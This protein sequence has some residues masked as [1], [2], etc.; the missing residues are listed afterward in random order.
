MAYLI[1]MLL[2]VTLPV[3][4]QLLSIA[5][6]P[7]LLREET[8]LLD[9]EGKALDVMIQAKSPQKEGRRTTPMRLS[10]GIEE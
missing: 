6:L 4:Q 3:K 5:D 8:A 2:Q 9:R 1:A 10:P 7:S